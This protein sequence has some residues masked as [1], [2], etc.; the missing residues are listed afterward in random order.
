[1]Y[2]VRSFFSTFIHPCPKNSL[3]IR[4]AGV[5]SGSF[6]SEPPVFMC[7]PHRKGPCKGS[8]LPEGAL[9]KGRRAL[10]IPTDKE[11]RA[12][13]AQAPRRHSW[14][15]M[16][17]IRKIRA[18]T[19]MMLLWQ[20]AR[21]PSAAAFLSKEAPER[22]KESGVAVQDGGALARPDNLLV[23]DLLEDQVVQQGELLGYFQ[24]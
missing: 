3:Q 18:R 11:A 15:C 21:K 1:M 22:H 13:A 14:L 17:G 9:G 24:G 8:S 7:V 23:G 20:R 6:H 4:N 12:V 5:V 16:N 19:G 2:G 10:G